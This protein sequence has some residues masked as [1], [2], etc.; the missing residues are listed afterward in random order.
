LYLLSEVIADSFFN[1]P[2]QDAWV[3]RSVADKTK[4]NCAFMPGRSRSCLKFHGV[5]IC[6]S[7]AAL[8]GEIVVGLVVDF[9]EGEGLAR[10]HVVGSDAQRVLFPSIGDE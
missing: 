8:R 5:M 4:F 7:D 9:D 1:Y 6:N 10:Y 3:Y 2:D